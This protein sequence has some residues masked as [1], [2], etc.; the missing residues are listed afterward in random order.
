MRWIVSLGV[1]LSLVACADLT[2][3]SDPRPNILFILVDD[4]SPA[5]LKLYNPQ[6][7]LQTPTLDR[8]A[9][10]GMVIDDAYH[11]GSFLAAVCTPSRHMIM[12]GRSLWHLPIS[13]QA[14][15]QGLA[16]EDLAQSTLPAIFQRAGYQTMRTCKIGNS[17][18]AA[19]QQFEVRKDATKR[20]GTDDEGSP[21]H[22]DQV[23][24]F[25]KERDRQRPFYIHLGF[26]HP[27]DPRHG[28]AHHMQTYGAVDHRDPSLPPPLN[29]HAPK[30][31]WNYLPQH[32]FSH[33]HPNLRDEDAVEGVWKR[34]DEATIRNELG[35]QFACSAWIDDQ[36]ARVLQNLEASGDL[37][38]TYVIYTSDHGMAIGRHGLQGKQSL[39]QHSWKVPLVVA[40]PGISPNSRQA[41]NVYLMDLLA[42]FCDLTGTP[43]PASN[44]GTSFAPV[45]RGE[46]KT[47]RDVLYG[48]YCGGT[49]PGIRSVKEG[50]WKLIEYE[51]LDGSIRETQLFHLEQNPDE[52]LEQHHDPTLCALTGN[53]PAP[54]Q[55]NLAYLP[56]HANT[57]DRLRLRLR[58]QMK[59]WQD[60]FTFSSLSPLP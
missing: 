14:R 2:R 19:N 23:L 54:N 36:I 39:Y 60:P 24:Q 56:E 28:P 43:V 21:W 13:P 31:P 12:S 50:P 58:E 8:L 25:L 44:E 1:F 46:K 40:G 9:R 5:D 51:L 20:E 37:D 29:S 57:R 11:M 16:P 30:L 45:L 33:G 7:T 48:V 42:T 47:I 3:A 52:L 4:Q 55:R 53:T 6:S 26:S 41:G 15:E 22:A 27:H 38:Q 49:K 18:E 32:P 17:Y 10:K 34:R 35:R 59:H